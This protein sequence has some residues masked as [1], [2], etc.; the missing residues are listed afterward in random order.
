MIQSLIQDVT[1]KYQSHPERLNHIKGVVSE[2]VKLAKHYH[3]NVDDATIAA[4]FHDYT[5]FDPIETQKLVLEANE[6]ESRMHQ[7]FMYHAYSAAKILK[8]RYHVNDDVYQAVYNH[9]WGRV[10]MSL[11]E[12]IILVA[13][14]I[15]PSRTYPIV[16]QLREIA[17][18]DLNLTIITYL[19]DLIETSRRKVL[20]EENELNKIIK[21]LKEPNE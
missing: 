12:K 15:E 4:W 6:I 17:Y 2:A 8:R 10:G 3:A 14:K 9:V 5:K 1:L 11:L 7:P 13:D 16:N 20:H 18:K 21:D 19:S